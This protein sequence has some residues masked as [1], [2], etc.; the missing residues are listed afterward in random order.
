MHFVLA[1]D[2]QQHHEI[3]K[4]RL[5]AVCTS[6]GIEINIG[7]EVEKAADV[8]DYAE[9]TPEET[10]WFLDIEFGEEMN[11]ID[12]CR[13]IRELNKNAYIIYVSAYQQYAL[14]CCQSHAFDFL[15]KPWTDEQLS[16]CLQ[17]VRQDQ[18]RRRAGTELIIELG[19]RTIRLIQ[20]EIL[21]FSKDRNTVIAHCAQG[22]TFTWRE[23][24]E[25][26][27][28]RLKHGL[29]FACHKSYL[30]NMSAIREAN[31]S[32]YTLL[33]LNGDAIP[34]S[35]RKEARLKDCGGSL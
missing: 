20:E 25:T 14:E 21:Y 10:V 29:F 35:R 2:Q 9:H 23:T 24:F 1:D 28:G 22:Q 7:L 27:T 32:T 34:V 16:A 6:L 26:L 17:A 30:V 4:Q 3:L 15:L 18:D 31:W 8:L 5:E 12:L 19:T 33:L 11:G 13:R